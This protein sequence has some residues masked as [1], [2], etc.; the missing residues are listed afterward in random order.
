MAINKNKAWKS[1]QARQI[2]IETETQSKL[3][4]D[5]GER[6]NKKVPCLRSGKSL[7]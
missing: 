4:I 1:Q 6:S 3:G 2:E 5:S 7:R